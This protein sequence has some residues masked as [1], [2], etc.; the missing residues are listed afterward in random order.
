[1]HG[2]TI[3]EA[4]RDKWGEDSVQGC[5]EDG[6]D[7]GILDIGATKAPEYVESGALVDIV[8]GRSQV[9]VRRISIVLTHT[10]A[11]LP[12]LG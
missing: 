11:P 4:N 12:E 5:N 8:W 1:M 7:R 3:V 9:S 10:M 6:Q 2:R